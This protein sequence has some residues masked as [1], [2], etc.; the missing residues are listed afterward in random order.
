MKKARK[1]K[2]PIIGELRLSPHRPIPLQENF[3]HDDR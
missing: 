1:I 2:P 3:N